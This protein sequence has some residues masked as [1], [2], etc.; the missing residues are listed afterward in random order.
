MSR[1]LTMPISLSTSS[2]TGRWRTRFLDI[3][4]WASKTDVSGPTVTTRRVID[5]LTN[6]GTP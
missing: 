4:S 5:L 6:I 1:S 3:S 2:T